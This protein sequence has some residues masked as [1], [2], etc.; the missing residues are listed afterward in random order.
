MLIVKYKRKYILNK[1]KTYL[2]DLR[3]P[4]PI[5]F[6]KNSKIKGFSVRK[7]CSKS[8]GVAV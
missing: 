8:Q 7:A 1:K 3:N 6:A 5:R 2:D 4:Q